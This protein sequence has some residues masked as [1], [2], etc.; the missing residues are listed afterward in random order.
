MRGNA[1]P[2]RWL[3]MPVKTIVAITRI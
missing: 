1:V 3:L 2:G